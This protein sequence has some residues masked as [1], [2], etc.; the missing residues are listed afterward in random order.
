LVNFSLFIPEWQ[1]CVLVQL[2][3][4]H[5]RIWLIIVELLNDFIFHRA[6]LCRAVVLV[7][8]AQRHARLALDVIQVEVV[9]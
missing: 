1:I 5:T 9:S 7:S 6:T 4:G 2:I 8:A 3:K